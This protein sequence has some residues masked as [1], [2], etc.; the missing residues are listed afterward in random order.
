MKDGGAI[1]DMTYSRGTWAAN[2]K[3]PDGKDVPVNGHWL[4]VGKCQDQI[5]LAMIHN[6]NMAMPSPK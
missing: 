5:C 3:V 4:I 1:G 2:M 6:G